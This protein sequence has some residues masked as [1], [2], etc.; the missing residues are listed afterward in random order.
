VH[1]HFDFAEREGEECQIKVNQF[2]ESLTIGKGASSFR[3]RRSPV[4]DSLNRSTQGNIE[5][6]MIK[7]F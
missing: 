6:I 1:P 2:D 7:F 5:E 4:P 3:F